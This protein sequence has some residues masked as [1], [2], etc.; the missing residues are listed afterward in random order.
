MQIYTDQ[1]QS[2]AVAEVFNFK[3]EVE[4]WDGWYWYKWGTVL[5]HGPYATQAEAIND[6]TGE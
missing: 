4:G 6:A 1:T 3:F 2:E 5:P